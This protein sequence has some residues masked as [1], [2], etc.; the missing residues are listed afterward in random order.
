MKFCSDCGSKVSLN[1]IE[2][3]LIPRFQ[4]KECNLI[5]YDNPKIIV[6]CLP[7]IEDEILLCKRAIEPAYGKWT[8]PAGFL[9]KNESV[10]E[11]ALRE[12]NEEAG[13]EPTIKRLFSI[14]SITHIGHIQMLFLSELSSRNYKAGIETLDVQ[15]FKEKDIPTDELAFPSIAYV[16]QKHFDDLRSGN[17]L[18][19][20]S[21]YP[22]T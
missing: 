9:E 4:C 12:A 2:N 14:F 6:G 8:L 21:S 19:H 7:Y 13:I 22:K 1:K 3:D 5:H 10:E 16:I 18:P 11:G 15:F 17:Q 20:F